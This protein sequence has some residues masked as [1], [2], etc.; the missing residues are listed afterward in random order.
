MADHVHMCL[1]I[2]PK[3]A[4]SQVVGYIKREERDPDRETA[5]TAMP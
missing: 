4:V 2:P 1:S 5:A 3:Y